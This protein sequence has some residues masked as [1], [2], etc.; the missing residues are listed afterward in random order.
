MKISIITV[1]FNS[2]E[3]IRDTIKSIISQDYE[4]IEYILIDAGSTDG[5]LDIIKE[6]E[7]YINYFS[8]EEDDGI[9]DGMNKGI[10]VASGEVVGILNS[11]DFYPNSYIV[12]NVARTFEKRNCDAVY[13]DLLYVKFYDTDKIVRYWQSGN[14]SVKKIKNGWML[15]HPT[16]FVKREMYEKY[17]YYN[18]ELKSAADYEMILKLLY[19]QN[20]NV[21]YIPMILVKMRMGGKSNASI[22]N[23]IRANKEDG[24]AWTENQL[25]KPL[26]VRIKKP[27]Q[28]IKQFFLKP[29]L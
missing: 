12:S 5:T 17:G 23:R 18:T 24:L 13:G 10:S 9:Y 14:Y 21:F 26:F 7:G 8:S 3:T 6:Y 28:K 15:P 2:V 29:K 27:L 1:S 19:K 11:D 4:N 20:I 25:Y 22:M 16:F